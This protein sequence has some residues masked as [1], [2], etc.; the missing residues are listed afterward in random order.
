MTPDEI[1]KALGGAAAVASALGTTYQAVHNWVQ[2]DRV[3][4]K[5][6]IRVWQMCVE[7]GVPWQPPG[8]EGWA[9]V[10]RGKGNV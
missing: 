5:K 6:Q 9:L 7:R 4:L 10:R 3:P 1:I 2:A 8:T